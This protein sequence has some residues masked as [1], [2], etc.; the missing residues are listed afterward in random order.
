MKKWWKFVKFHNLRLPNFID[1]WDGS[2][3]A[4]L[5]ARIKIVRLQKI[6]KVDVLYYKG[7]ERVRCAVK[8]GRKE[9]HDLIRFEKSIKFCS[10]SGIIISLETMCLS[11]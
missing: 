8:Q 6:I 5:L 2:S 3:T 11:A 10:G 1:I 9:V 7:V 4:L